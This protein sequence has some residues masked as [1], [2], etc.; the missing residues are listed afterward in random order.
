MILGT[1]REKRQKYFILQVIF[2]FVP[3]MTDLEPTFLHSA[4]N[5]VL[6]DITEVSKDILEET[7]QS[8][9][10]ETSD[11]F[12]FLEESDLCPFKPESCL[13]LGN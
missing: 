6:P 11:D 10:I 3:E 7:L 13:L 5:E 1:G 2:L 9:G 4:I 12:K 8:L